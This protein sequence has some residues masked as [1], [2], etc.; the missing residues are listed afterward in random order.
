M[1]L[2]MMNGEWNRSGHAAHSSPLTMKVEE[3]RGKQ[4]RNEEERLLVFSLLFF[5][6][7]FVV[8]FIPSFA[9]QSFRRLFLVF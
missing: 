5:A 3:C 8:W 9:R 2:L 7:N 1:V 4:M 6:T